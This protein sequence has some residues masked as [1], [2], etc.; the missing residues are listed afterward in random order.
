MSFYESIAPWYN[1]IF[2]FSPIQVSFIERKAGSLKAKNVVD[3]GC[4][5]GSL[6]FGMADRG[7]S[8]EAIDLDPFMILK[9]REQSCNFG[10]SARVLF[11][12]LN[13][14]K[15]SKEFKAQSV[16][17]V[18]SFGNTLVHLLKPGEL[19]SFFNQV[20]S[21]LKPEG[22][23]IFQII[24]YDFVLDHG[25]DRLPDIE[26]D[27]IHFRRL[28]E[29][30]EQDELINFKTI[31]TI[32]ESNKKIENVVPL[33]PVRADMLKMLFKESLFFDVEFFGDFDG[34]PLLSRSMKLI[35]VAA[36]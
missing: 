24:N 28:Y 12:E 26:N 17:V 35:G 30:R 10:N 29:F 27:T 8:V 16:D 21:I 32:K 13:M 7:A 25:V 23:F 9:A 19:L 14:L 5:I 22:K 18:V 2:P 31:L 34:S 15:L 6:S 36:F 11:K 3:I 20:A 1:Y 33:Q 4:G